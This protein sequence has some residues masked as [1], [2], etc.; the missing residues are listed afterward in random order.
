M[1]D[2]GLANLAACLL[3]NNHEVRIL[4][5][6]TIKVMEQLKIPCNEGK[7]LQE[8]T[9]TLAQDLQSGKEPVQD[10]LAELKYLEA[11]IKEV[12][13]QKVL[14]IA[15][16]IVRTVEQEGADFVGFKLWNGDGFSGSLLIAQELRK[17]CPSLPLFAGGP[18]V[19]WFRESILEETKCFDA[20][21]YGEGEETIVRLAEYVE[22]KKALREIPNLIFREDDAIISTPLKRIESLESLPLPVYDEEIY[23]AMKGNQKIKL[24]TYDESRGC[25]FGCYF[26][27][28]PIKSGSRLRTKN[29]EIVVDE[30]EQLVDHYRFNTFRYAGSST[31]SRLAKNIAREILS[32]GLKIRYSSFSRAAG[33]NYEDF[34][35]LKESGC[36][37]LFFGIETG[38]QEL[39]TKMIGKKI[40]LDQMKSTLFEAKKAGLFTLASIIFPLPGETEKTKKQT[41]DFL[42]DI[43]P[44]AVPLSPPGLIPGT[45]WTKHVQKYGF[46]LEPGF[47]KK[48]MRYKI[49]LLYPGILW[50]PLPYQVDGKSSHQFLGELNE[51]SSWLEKNGLLTMFSDDMALIAE[52]T[53]LKPR[54]LRDKSRQIFSSGDVDGLASL[55]EK[56]NSNLCI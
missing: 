42:F 9:R 51:F 45:D 33:L 39:L 15:R 32:R 41:L 7:N 47:K 27:V 6:G 38:S 25:P 40:R 21:V 50:D 10:K 5:Y 54:D 13:Q 24:I 12:Y 43:K 20:L 22:G 23:P 49:K 4:D 17:S 3:S 26:C 2:N 14:V 53:N 56:V 8:L 55:V 44:N 46:Q 19:D 28:Q 36:S 1:P 35:L 30:I 37:A 11:G 29:A 34:K 48:L 31:P 52:L 18:Q 16:E